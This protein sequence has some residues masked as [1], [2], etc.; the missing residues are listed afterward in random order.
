MQGAA[1]LNARSHAIEDPGPDSIFETEAVNVVR[2]F[3][4]EAPL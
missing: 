1:N 4:V 2:K 3:C